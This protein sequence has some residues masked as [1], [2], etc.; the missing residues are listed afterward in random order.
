[1]TK[2]TIFCIVLRVAYKTMTIT[3]CGNVMNLE[4]I[5]YTILYFPRHV[6]PYVFLTE[7]IFLF[8]W[9]RTFDYNKQTMCRYS[10]L[11]G[12]SKTSTLFTIQEESNLRRMLPNTYIWSWRIN[13]HKRTNRKTILFLRTISLLTA[14]S[15]LC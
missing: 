1:M 15:C 8:L 5:L 11:C 13:W 7:F 4:V 9:N 14:N 12:F 10:H 3:C 6:T 2:V